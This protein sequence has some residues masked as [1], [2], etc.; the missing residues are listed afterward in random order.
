LSGLVI[1]LIETPSVNIILK[2]SIKKAV[3]I[4][5]ST[6]F[7]MLKLVNRLPIWVLP[8]LQ[9]FKLPNY[10]IKIRRKLYDF[11]GIFLHL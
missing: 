5:F 10:P 7:L 1:I 8:Y 11:Q 9:I 2:Y 6:A 3:E 4:S